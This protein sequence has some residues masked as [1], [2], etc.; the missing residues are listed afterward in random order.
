[1]Q[2]PLGSW[3]PGPRSIELPQ[4]QTAPY[5]PKAAFAQDLVEG[6]VLN[7]APG[8][9][10]PDLAV[11]PI[12]CP[13]DGT[14][15]SGVCLLSPLPWGQVVGWGKGPQRGRDSLSRGGVSLQ[16]STVEGGWVPSW[17][18]VGSGNFP[19]GNGPSFTCDNFSRDFWLLLKILVDPN[20][21]CF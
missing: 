1:M 13:R 14:L 3:V 15:D 7:V 21:L 20:G 17:V 10:L 11:G 12:V 16:V 2:V 8:A 18:L 9:A 5:L 6:E 4:G 19:G